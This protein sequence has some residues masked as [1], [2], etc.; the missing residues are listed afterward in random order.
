[1]LAA[2]A[3]NRLW[4]DATGTTRETLPW[5]PEQ[6]LFPGLLVVALAVVGLRWRGATVGLR[7]GLAAGTALTVLLSFGLRLWGGL[8][9]SPLLHLPGW[10][11]LR[12]TG[13]LAFLW[14]LGLAVLAGFGAQRLRELLGRRLPAAVPIG[15]AA[16]L[17]LAVGYEG[18]PR[19]PVVPVPPEPA[20]LAT[21]AGPR[22]HLPSD[23][24]SDTAYM[25]WSTDGF[26]RIANGG[27]SYTPKALE[28]LRRQTTGFPDAASVA[29]LRSLGFRTVVV[30]RDRL[31]G[32]PWQGAAD[33]PVDGLGITRTDDGDV[34]VYDLNG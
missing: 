14:S 20:A 19:L 6:A 30:H 23:G 26:P 32:T 15:A 27:A 34:V 10:Q 17:A 12:T 28:E 5:A 21:A 3:D 25:L 22:L 4:G 9:Y 2:A 29:L 1:V 7:V 31:A 11:G 13:R 16:A 18:M 24:L 33:R 8:L